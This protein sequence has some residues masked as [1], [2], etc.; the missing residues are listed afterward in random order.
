MGLYQDWPMH[1]LQDNANNGYNLFTRNDSFILK[2]D[3]PLMSDP[4]SELSIENDTLKLSFGIWANIGSWGVSNNDY[5]FQYKNN[6]FVLIGAK[7]F[8]YS[9]NT[10]ESTEY[11]FDFL[12]KKYI[13]TDEYD[14][15]EV[16]KTSSL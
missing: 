13:K 15:E 5:S 14:A 16:V 6:N 1:S 12:T 2:H 8:N 3:D 4:F 10:G 7:I 11:R 9:R